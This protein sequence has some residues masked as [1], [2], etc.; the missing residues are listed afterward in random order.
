MLVSGAYLCAGT[1]EQRVCVLL[2]MVCMH[3]SVTCRLE[4]VI[5]KLAAV[6]AVL[7][8]VITLHCHQQGNQVW[9]SYWAIRSS[10]YTENKGINTEKPGQSWKDCILL[11]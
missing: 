3:R 8:G 9:N 5:E 7:H 10:V 11:V 2:V 4:D 6:L 1:C